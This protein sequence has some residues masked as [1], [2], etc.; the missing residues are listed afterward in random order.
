MLNTLFLGRLMIHPN[1]LSTHPAFQNNGVPLI[2]RTELYY[3]G[4]SQG[5]IM[6]GAATAISID[7]TRAALGVTGMNYS[8]LLQRSVDWDTYRQ[9]YDPAYPNVIERGI[10]LLLLQ[11][12]WDRGEA[13]GYAQHITDDPL[14]N[15]PAHKVLM[16]VAFGDWQ[17]SNATAD[18]E[19]RSVGAHLHTP[20]V[21]D[22]RLAD[23]MTPFWNIP[24]IQSYPFDGS[25][26]VMWDSG[27]P[28]APTVNLA[29]SQGR[30]PHED[31]RNSPLARQQKSEFLKPDGAVV[32]VCSGLPCMADPA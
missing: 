17:V 4:N 1:G 31:P 8:T 21:T 7:W 3:D 32:D 30:D 13:D 6:G 11:M 29:P 15:T 5:G 27:T 16:H 28:E 23:Y 12:L 18:V 25:A 9:I 14:P 19:A 24:P 20:A 22:G 26:M 10:G 2:D